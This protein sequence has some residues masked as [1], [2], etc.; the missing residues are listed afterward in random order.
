M[1]TT[2]NLLTVCFLFLLGQF[3][4][5]CEKEDME[6]FNTNCGTNDSLKSAIVIDPIPIIKIVFDKDG[7]IYTTIK[8]GNQTWLAQNL[9]TTLYNDGTAISDDEL[10]WDYTWYN[11]DTAY[12]YRYGALY[13]WNAVNS[14]KLAPTGWHVATDAD[15]TI[16]T[17]YLGGTGVAGGKLKEAGTSHWLSPNT[18]ATNE[19]SF[20][21]L[22][23]GY[24][25]HYFDSPCY[26]IGKIGYWWT[27]TEAL[28]EKAW[29]RYMS[30]NNDDVVRIYTDKEFGFS[31]RCVKN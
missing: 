8:I 29:C 9:K 2:F 24:C 4:I 19:V 11:H 30:Y 20:R 26:Q 27:A 3:F 6:E 5:G 18:G 31:V 17:S 15:W 22:P 14:G 10:Y 13:S 7:N 21:A 12:K 23:G 28:E 25:T 16:L 1:K